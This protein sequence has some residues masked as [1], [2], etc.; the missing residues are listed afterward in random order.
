MTQK[1]ISL[2]FV[3]LLVAHWTEHIVQAYQVYVMGMPRHHALGLLGQFYPTIVHNESLH[4][5]FAVLT[6]VG[7]SMLTPSF[8]YKPEG[9]WWE[10]AFVIACW[11]CMEH[12]LLFL[13][14]QTG[15]YLNGGYPI[16]L[17]QFFVPRIELHLFYNTL[18]TIPIVIAY[19]LKYAKKLQTA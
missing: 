1:R 2:I 3:V 11:H 5:V 15:V 18:V 8:Q 10:L 16:S 14:A 17:L 13:Q 12:T 19:Y 9:Y 4:F 6:L 7:I